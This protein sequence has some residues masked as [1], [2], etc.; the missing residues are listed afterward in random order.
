MARFA[1]C[2]AAGAVLGACAALPGP[3][4]VSPGGFELSGRVVIRHAKD[5]GSG[6]IFWR[7]S[8]DTDELLIT[9]P[10][11]QGVARISRE[12][13]RFE[14]VTGEGKEYRAADAESLTEQ[15]L[16]WRLPLSGL[17][18]WVQARASP[19]RPAEI[20]GRADEGLEIRQDGWKVTYGEFRQGRPFR[21]SLARE[22]LEIRLVVDRWA[23]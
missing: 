15:A 23:N 22:D 1:L 18:D 8:I 9:S 17:S 2:I 14:L 12:G 16:G 13:D 11:G 19:G 21:L 4:P 7:H 6:R 20:R 5:S 3:R 10:I